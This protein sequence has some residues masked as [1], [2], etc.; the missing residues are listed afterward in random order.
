MVI[1]PTCPFLSIICTKLSIFKELFLPFHPICHQARFF[2]TYLLYILF[3]ILQSFHLDDEDKKIPNHAHMKILNTEQTTN[4]RLLVKMVILQEDKNYFN[5]ALLLNTVIMLCILLYRIGNGGNKLFVFVFVPLLF[6]TWKNY[7]LILCW[8]IYPHQPS[9][10]YIP[11]LQH[12]TI[13][14]TP[15]VS[16]YEIFWFSA[17]QSASDPFQAVPGSSM[18]RTLTMEVS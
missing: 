14:T 6:I 12:F 2:I 13:S 3:L 18:A 11:Q 5:C 8:H 16:L 10:H 4:Q 7:A 9:F 15:K 17:F 1:G